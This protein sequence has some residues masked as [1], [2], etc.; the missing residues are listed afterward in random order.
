MDTYTPCLWKW[1][2]EVGTLFTQGQLGI[3]VDK[4]TD[5]K[6]CILNKYLGN[7]IKMYVDV[8]Q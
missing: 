2:L 8:N 3:P 1:R 7:Y 6:E 5:I 4:H